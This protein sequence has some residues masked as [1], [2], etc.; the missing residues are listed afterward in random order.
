[1][2]PPA[3]LSDAQIERLSDLLEKYALPAQSFNLE[4]LDGFLRAN[5]FAGERTI[6]RRL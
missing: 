2:N 3:Y 6:K 4:A 1:M 5:R